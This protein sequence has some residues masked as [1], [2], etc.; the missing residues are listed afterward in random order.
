M[1]EDNTN[2]D[3]RSGDDERRRVTR[4]GVC[5]AAAGLVL[6]GASGT[7]TAQETDPERTIRIVSTG[8]ERVFYEIGVSG[9]IE[10]GD[11]ADLTDASHPDGVDDRRASGSTVD[12]GADSYRF[13]GA[14][15][16][17][18]VD[19]PAAVY[20][21]GERIDPADYGEGDESAA[22]ALDRSLRIVSTGDERA[23]YEIAVSEEIAPGEE[24]NLTDATHP[25]SVEGR[26]AAGAVT[27]GGA[28]SY[29]FSGEV[30]AVSLEGPA[31]VF[32]DGDAFALEEDTDEATPERTGRVTRLN[33]PA[34]ATVPPETGIRFTIGVESE[35]FFPRW[36]VDGESFDPIGPIHDG[37]ALGDGKE[38]FEH[39]FPEEGTYRV[40]A[41]VFESMQYDEGLGTVAWEIEVSSGEYARP[42]VDLVAPQADQGAL[43]SGRAYEYTVRARD[44]DG[45]LSHVA[46]WLSHCDTLLGIS[47]LSGAEDTATITHEA[48]EFCF[49]VPLV[50]DE[51]GL[52]TDL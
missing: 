45:N 47:P 39:S 46:W 2:H 52:A 18:T 20:V 6:A 33:P 41:E 26:T 17:L 9:R 14:I 44:P 42:T 23:F 38:F 5:T 8:D 50:V 3:G 12:G 21:D 27:E 36:H 1:G 10:A 31:R 28:D 34:R 29:R 22:E 30:T 35:N 13:S 37:Y 32:V 19:G 11:E 4:R 51:T 25:D 40:R 24:A 48:D 43:E 16:A 15:T 7:G 49:V